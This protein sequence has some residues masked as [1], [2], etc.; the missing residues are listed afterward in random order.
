[1]YTFCSSLHNAKCSY[2]MYLYLIHFY[3]VQLLLFCKS[4]DWIYRKYDAFRYPDSTSWST[5]IIVAHILDLS[6]PAC[7]VN[8]TGLWTSHRLL[9]HPTATVMTSCTRSLCHQEF[10]GEQGVGITTWN[11]FW[12][13]IRNMVTHHSCESGRGTW[14]KHTARSIPPVSQLWL[15]NLNFVF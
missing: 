14:G 15:L 6:R 10:C 3:C 9:K 7:L 2:V 4:I 1:M 5:F 12:K 11:T 13:R 8:K